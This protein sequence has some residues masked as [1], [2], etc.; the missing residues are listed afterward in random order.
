MSRTAL[1]WPSLVRI[2]SNDSACQEVAAN[3]NFDTAD[4][5]P[6]MSKLNFINRNPLSA[7]PTRFPWHPKIQQ[8]DDFQEI[9]LPLMV[10]ASVAGSRIRWLSTT[11]LSLRMKMPMLLLSPK[12]H[13][14]CQSQSCVR[15]SEGA[16]LTGI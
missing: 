16:R 3:K 4:A 10:T 9:A 15:T 11:P 6:L 12:E 14:M 8:L 7:L 2:E 13:I 1:D 5:Q